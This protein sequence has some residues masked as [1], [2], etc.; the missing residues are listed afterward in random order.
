MHFVENFAIN[1]LLLNA[2]FKKEQKRHLSEMDF[3]Q[4]DDI[5]RI[6]C[7]QMFLKRGFLKKIA[8]FT[9]KRMYWSLFLIKLI[10]FRPATLFKRNS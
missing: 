8:I 4:E 1:L 10:G 6:S 9:G 7:S 2:S 3:H 5:I